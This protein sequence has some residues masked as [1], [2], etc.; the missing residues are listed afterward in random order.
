M[1]K[2]KEEMAEITNK[3]LL[4][5]SLA[6]AIKGADVFIGLSVAG[7]LKPEMVKTMTSNPIFFAMTNP[8]PEIMPAE[9]K[10]AGT[11]V[12]ATGFYKCSATKLFSSFV[13]FYFSQ[14]ITPFI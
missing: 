8:I 2:A 7:V 11:G 14:F 1:N 4:K 12:V 6:D 13:N 9:S 3:N 5:G 10:A